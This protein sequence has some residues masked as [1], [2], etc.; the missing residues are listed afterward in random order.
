MTIFAVRGPDTLQTLQKS[1]QK[2]N[3][4]LLD[5][6]TVAFGD[7]GILLDY[8][9]MSS[10]S[11]RMQN[12]RQCENQFC[13]VPHGR[14][15]EKFIKK[16]VNE[17]N[18]KRFDPFV[19][20]DVMVTQLES[21]QYVLCRSLHC[22]ILSDA[23]RIPNVFFQFPNTTNKEPIHKYK[24]YY[25]MFGISAMEMPYFEDVALATK[26]L[27]GDKHVQLQHHQTR[28][29]DLYDSFPLFLFE[30]QKDSN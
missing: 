1:R 3:L 23:M 15:Q 2:S 9:G 14:D 8:L 19:T 16:A 13:L 29:N 28:I 17:G 20:W 30:E 26:Y 10:G 22:I 27:Q 5:N 21:C 7:P 4:T 24:D 25:A 18:L 6:N 11:C 12:F